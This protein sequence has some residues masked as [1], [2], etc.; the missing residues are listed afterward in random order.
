[1]KTVIV[2]DPDETDR[3]IA[4]ALLAGH[5]DVICCASVVEAIAV[6]RTRQPHAVVMDLASSMT[7]GQY[8]P[9]GAA[10]RIAPNAM[11]VCST[12][13]S[14]AV[15]YARRRGASGL[16]EKPYR[17]DALAA[18]VRLASSEVAAEKPLARPY[19]AAAHPCQPLI[20]DGKA[21]QEVARR[22]VLYSR[23]DAPVLILGETGTGK[24]LAAQAIHR[25]SS[26]RRA[27]FLAVDCASIPET[28]A[29]SLLFGTTKGAF[30]GSMDQKGIF[31]SSFGGTV[32]LDEVGE[33]SPAIQ[34]KFLRT[35]ESGCGT[36]VGSVDAITYD[37]R[38][39]SATDASIYE[40]SGHFRPELLNRL[41]TLE[42]KM[43]PLRDH[44][45][46]I[47]A[48]IELFI[49]EFCSGKHFT[50]NALDKLQ[51][52]NWPGNVRELRNI[53]QRASVLSGIR[54]EMHAADIELT[55]SND[56]CRVPIG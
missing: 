27:R 54:E 46:D 35:L 20:G 53:V 34:A 36:R 50:S 6:A 55:D 33:L 38:I 37:V 51:Q 39:L 52:W 15:D 11:V 22:I 13:Q 49:S 8:D 40:D 31:E 45:E 5:Y 28:L 48:L 21:M 42:L 43:P 14:T 56:P 12:S 25:S 3:K 47:P 41:N 2:V 32:F 44:K 30:T 23:Y 17:A 4:L 29:E 26:R 7:N 19:G 10:A 24:E 1:M 16:I 9:I 18:A